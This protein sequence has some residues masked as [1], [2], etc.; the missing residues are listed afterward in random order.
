[1]VG[2]PVHY[3]GALR[4]RKNDEQTRNEF[5]RNAKEDLAGNEWAAR[6]K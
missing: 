4:E 1:M 2:G 6:I 3:L 5:V